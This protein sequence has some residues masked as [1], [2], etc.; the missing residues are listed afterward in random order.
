MPVRVDSRVGDLFNDKVVLDRGTIGRVVGNLGEEGAK[1]V[2][3]GIEQVGT[4]SL[5]PTKEAGR[6]TRSWFFKPRNGE[7]I[8]VS[9]EGL[10][11]GKV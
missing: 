11:A 5:E 3:D 10:S 7:K 6:P 9:E 4:M 2:A 8:F 1:L